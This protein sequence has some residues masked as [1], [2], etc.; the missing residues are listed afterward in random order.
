MQERLAACEIDLAHAVCRRCR[1]RRTYRVQ[2]HEAEGRLARACPERR[3]GAAA[4]EAVAALDVAAG[5]ADLDPEVVEVSQLD[6]RRTRY[7][8]HGCRG[9]RLQPALKMPSP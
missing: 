7:R 8:L 6:S 4:V 9:A 2:C 1:N 5:P 3:R